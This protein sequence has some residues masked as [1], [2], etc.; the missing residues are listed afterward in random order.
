MIGTGTR[1]AVLTCMA[2]LCQGCG[3]S[4]P[5]ASSSSELGHPEQVDPREC[6]ERVAH[7]VCTWS[8][9]QH[10]EHQQSMKQ[11]ARESDAMTQ[12]G[13]GY[14]DV[15]LRSM[16]GCWVSPFGS[17]LFQ[18]QMDRDGWY[19]IA[20]GGPGCEKDELS[21]Q[22]RKYGV[23]PTRCGSTGHVGVRHSK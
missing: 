8:L 22:A 5:Q 23:E 21:D 19:V 7:E 3:P 17:C 15:V 2:C 13:E 14:I 10:A 12:R 6:A 1:I 20:V 18:T 16:C 4:C 11:L 9:E